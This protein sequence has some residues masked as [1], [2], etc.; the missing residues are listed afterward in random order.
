MISKLLKSF[1]SFLVL[2]NWALVSEAQIP[3]APASVLSPNA[4]NFQLFGDIPVSYFTGLASTELPIYTVTE[5]PIAVPVSLA[6]HASGFRPDQHPG[7]VGAGWDLSTGGAVTR[8]ARDLYDE[9]SSNNGYGYQDGYYYE[10]SY[11]DVA[12]WNTKN[13][14]LYL[15]QNDNGAPRSVR[16]TE[17][18]EFSFSFAGYSGKF[19]MDEKGSWKVQSDKPL[20]V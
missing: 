3:T 9:H 20:K 13:G 18:D 15:N 6:Y 8:L 11:L 2:V 12:N 4:S 10:H 5:G 17:P 7:W 16:D 19:F 14:L 1:L